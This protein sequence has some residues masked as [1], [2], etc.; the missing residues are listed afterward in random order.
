MKVY[1]EKF[2]KGFGS[3]AI[4]LTYRYLLGGECDTSSGKFS[5]TH[6]NGWTI[7]GT[8][9][10]DYY[11]WINEFEATHPKLGKVWGNF[12]SE[13]F[14]TSKEGYKD[15]SEKFPVERWDYRDI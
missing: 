2:T 13:V 1:S 7:K 12:E 9:V 6:D 5:K 10:E 14:F 3:Q 8:V 15:F 4:T 11:R